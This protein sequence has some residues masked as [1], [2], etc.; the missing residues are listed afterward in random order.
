MG[1]PPKS[2]ST[3][4]APSMSRAYSPPL[5]P[6]SQGAFVKVA[7]PPASQG[8][9]AKVRR[10]GCFCFCFWFWFEKGVRFYPCPCVFG[11]W[12]SHLMCV[13]PC[14]VACA[15]TNTRAD[16]WETLRRTK[17]WAGQ[18]GGGGVPSFCC[19][20]CQVC[21]VA[22]LNY[23]QKRKRKRNVSAPLFFFFCSC[24]NFCGVHSHQ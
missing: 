24:C 1:G 17:R 18:V 4:G 13:F 12:F 5:P 8:A 2:T 21:T 20:V 11:S 16:R 3:G 22:G 7:G 15:H 10:L 14:A 9:F 19:L 6:S 23:K